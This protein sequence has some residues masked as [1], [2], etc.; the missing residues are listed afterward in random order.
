M[1]SQ[2]LKRFVGG[3]AL[4]TLDSIQKRE[5]YNREIE[6]AK[7]LEQLRTEQAKELADY[8]ELINRR[9]PSKD[10]SSTDFESGKRVLRNEYGEKIGELD[11]TASDKFAYEAEKR[12]AQLDEENTR[13]QIASRNRDDARQ[14]RSTNAYIRSLDRQGRSDTGG[15]GKNGEVTDIDRANELM[16]RYK[17]E[18]DATVK[19]GNVSEPAVRQAA[20]AIMGEAKNGEEAQRAFLTWLNRYRTG[21][22]FTDE[23][24]RSLDAAE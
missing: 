11:V 23:R 8:Q 13:S 15:S 22:K 19:S 2:A 16:Y 10:L 6:K 4:S 18:V 9:K 3:F 24:K 14:D 12:K 20:I 5:A 17:G 21:R 1:A 7:M